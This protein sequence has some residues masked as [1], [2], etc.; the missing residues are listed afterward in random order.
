MMQIEKM[1]QEKETD[2]VK[3]ATDKL[4]EY[5]NEIRAGAKGLIIGKGSSAEFVKG[6]K[7]EFAKC[8]NPIPGDEVIGFVTQSEGI[9]VHRKN[10]RNI[11]NLFLKEPERVIEIKLDD[12]GTGDFTGGIKII[13]E[14][15]PGML[16]EITKALLKN[17]K[18]NIRSINFSS[19][20]SVFEGTIILS[21]DNLKQLNEII[22]KINSQ[23]G[24]FSASR[25]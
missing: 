12:S 1:S 2:T 11:I 20:G 10:C 7:Y 19:K 16:N 17:Y 22:D 3:T 21:V 13:G 9:K 15:K 24:I 18:V 25:I 6:I 23:E 8:C 14:D 4:N 5:V